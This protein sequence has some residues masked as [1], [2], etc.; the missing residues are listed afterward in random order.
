V[1]GKI[2]QQITE[3]PGKSVKAFGICGEQIAQVL[4]GDSGMMGFQ[5]LPDRQVAG[6]GHGQ[7]PYSSCANAGETGRA[8]AIDTA[9][10]TEMSATSAA[11]SRSSGITIVSGGVAVEFWPILHTEPVLATGNFCI[12]QIPKHTDGLARV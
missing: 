11:S 5:L 1:L 4:V 7:L 2:D 10:L 8:L 3:P 6:N 12:G 9:T